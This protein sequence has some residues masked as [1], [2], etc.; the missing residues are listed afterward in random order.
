MAFK[1][2]NAFKRWMKSIEVYDDINSMRPACMME[3]ISE[4]LPT[5]LKLWI[6][7]QKCKTI[8]DMARAADQYVVVRKSFLPSA[9]VQVSSKAGSQNTSAVSVV[10]FN[11]SKNY[12]SYDTPQYDKFTRPTYHKTDTASNARS[13]ESNTNT[14]PGNQIG[15]K[16]LRPLFKCVYCAKPNHAASECRKRMANEEKG[17]KMAKQPKQVYLLI[18]VLMLVLGRCR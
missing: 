18:K 7:D 12:R 11:N 14:L 3:Q 2:Q 1:L 4:L 10:G 5:D 9:D 17:I 8:E 6:V 13:K 15:A 16:K